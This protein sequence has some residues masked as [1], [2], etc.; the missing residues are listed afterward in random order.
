MAVKA[1]FPSY[2]TAARALTEISHILKDVLE[3][4]WSKKTLLGYP[5]AS[6]SY[7][8]HCVLAS[9]VDDGWERSEWVGPGRRC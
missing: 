7:W 8:A 1:V 4:V 2:R 6:R 5:A 9:M 3:G